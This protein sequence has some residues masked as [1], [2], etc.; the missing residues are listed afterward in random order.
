MNNKE[1]QILELYYYYYIHKF[2]YV[3]HEII[4]FPS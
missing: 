2:H 1:K 4:I 3:N